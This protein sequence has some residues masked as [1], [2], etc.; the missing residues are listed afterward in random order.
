MRY[1]LKLPWST[2][3]RAQVLT[4]RLKRKWSDGLLKPLIC[5]CLECREGGL[6]VM[7]YNHCRWDPCR[8]LCLVWLPVDWALSIKEWLW[9]PRLALW[10]GDPSFISW[11]GET[12]STERMTDVRR[13]E[14]DW[15]W[16]VNSRNQTHSSSEAESPLDPGKRR[17]WSRL[18]TLPLSQPPSTWAR[19][20]GTT[21]TCSQ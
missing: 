14:M 5:R 9:E 15:L 1:S 13:E 20:L 16:N 10:F 7:G 21:K 19:N 18:P 3:R 12:S 11:K 8:M 4:W 2:W 6:W 17:L